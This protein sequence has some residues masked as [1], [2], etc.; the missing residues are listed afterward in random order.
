MC[1]V[2]LNSSVEVCLRLAILALHELQHTT[3]TISIGAVV[4]GLDR[5][6]KVGI[7][8]HRIT[9]LKMTD[10]TIEVCIRHATI[11]IYEECEV[12]DR[13]LEL[14]IKQACDTSTIIRVWKIGAKVDCLGEIFECIIVITKT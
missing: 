12:G 3:T 10:T 1:R 4:V 6:V 7:G 8:S 13:L 5:L 11:L 14:L 9:K 2:V